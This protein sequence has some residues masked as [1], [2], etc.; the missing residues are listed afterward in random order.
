MLD[1]RWLSAARIQTRL[2]EIAASY[3]GEPGTVIQP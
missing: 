1:G 2:R 3:Q